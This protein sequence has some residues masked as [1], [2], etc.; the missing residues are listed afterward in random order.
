MKSTAF[1]ISILVIVFIV[2]SCSKQD[3]LKIISFYVVNR[4][5]TVFA[6]NKTFY[7]RQDYF[8]VKNYVEN[9]ENFAAI[10]EYACENK[11]SNGSQYDEYSMLFY[12]MSRITNNKYIAKKRKQFD[13]YSQDHD[14][15]CQY[16]WLKNKPNY[17]REKTSKQEPY[18]I[19]DFNCR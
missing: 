7:Y 9:A 2:A 12:R 19:M 6:N 5:D 8:L 14:Y 16:V 18:R 15:I 10:E 13:R 4:I 1:L 3:E 17:K 11:G